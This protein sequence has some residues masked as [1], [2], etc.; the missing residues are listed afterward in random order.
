[1]AKNENGYW[2]P[3]YSPVEHVIPE[4]F[5]TKVLAEEAEMLQAMRIS[6]KFFDETKNFKMA[7]KLKGLLVEWSN[8][9][10]A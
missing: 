1:M 8:H 4:P 3:E 9:R 6:V 2:W 10:R 7:S 5:E